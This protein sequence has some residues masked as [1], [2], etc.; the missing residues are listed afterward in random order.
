MRHLI[1][2]AILHFKDM[3]GQGLQTVTIEGDSPEMH[4]A[5]FNTT[6]KI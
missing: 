5:F 4:F 3:D 6:I 1:S 2:I